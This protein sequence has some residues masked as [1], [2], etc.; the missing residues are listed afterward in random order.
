MYE[1]IC[2]FIFCCVYNDLQF[3]FHCILF[4]R[5]SF[6]LA[7]ES[8]CRAQ[9]MLCSS[10][11][12]ESLKKQNKKPLTAKKT[13]KK[14]NKQKN[15][16]LGCKKEGRKG[17]A[18]NPLSLKSDLMYSVLLKPLSCSSVNAEKCA[19]PL[20]RRFFRLHSLLLWINCSCSKFFFKP[21]ILMS[22]WF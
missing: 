14:A 2:S 19:V 10:E 21:E 12:I 11:V 18:Y 4:K 6:F 22:S 13:T 15:N 1:Y 9:N 7:L 5:H 3:R 17:I 20:D 8:T 16:G